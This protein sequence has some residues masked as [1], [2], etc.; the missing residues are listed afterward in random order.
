M[1]PLSPAEL[2]DLSGKVALITGAARGIGAACAGQLAAAGARVLINARSADGAAAEL[3]SELQQAGGQAELCLFDVADSAA[4]NAAFEQIR[5]EHGRLDILVNNAGKR[6]DGL[7][8]RMNDEQ[9]DDV[10]RV[11]LDG[12]FFCCRAALSLMRQQGGS[13][14]NIASVAAFAGSAGQ[15]NYSAAKAG[16]VGL[17]RSLALE[18]G[19]KNIRV[20][21]VI[22]GIIETAMTADVKDELKQQW[23]SQI[24]LKRLG[25][26]AEV[27]SV[28]HFLCSPAASYITGA[29]LHVNG[30]GYLC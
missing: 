14:V 16:V 20:N 27:A 18:Y 5:S 24:A 23:V 1:T 17:T 9:W 29:M 3:L 15:V 19:G 22:P 11:N 26:P 21:C 25:D 12:V 4:I 8:L 6:N 2:M 28:V 7:A 30:G 10:L 13:I